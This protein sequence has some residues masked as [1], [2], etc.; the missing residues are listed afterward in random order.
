[1]QILRHFI[2]ILQPKHLYTSS[3]SSLNCFFYE[4]F[5]FAT[6]DAQIQELLFAISVE[7]VCISTFFFYLQQDSFSSSIT[8]RHTKTY[9]KRKITLLLIIC[10]KPTAHL[11]HPLPSYF[12]SSS[13]VGIHRVKTYLRLYITYSSL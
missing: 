8:N 3:F 12:L 2:I 7:C 11:S 9:G 13:F 1:M 6:K 4:T 10:I 5:Y